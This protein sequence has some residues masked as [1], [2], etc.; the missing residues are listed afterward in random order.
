MTA[1]AFLGHA[2]I[3]L[4]RVELLTRIGTSVDR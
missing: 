3:S 4:R 1:T 2:S